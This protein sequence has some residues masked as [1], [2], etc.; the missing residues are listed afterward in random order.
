MHRQVRTTPRKQP[1]QERSKA[2][3]ET[4]LEATARVLVKR[5]YDGLTTN[6][7][8]IAAGV[9][10]GSLYQY[11]PNKEALVAGLIGRHGD[12]MVAAVEKE[13]ARVATLPIPQAVRAM[14]ELTIRAHAIEPELH[15][16]LLEQV[17]RTG[18][19]A[20]V[21]ELQMITQRQVANLL[22][23]RR[24]ELAIG[25]PEIAAFLLVS[26][27]EAVAHRAALF[28]PH[29]LRD[30]KLIDEATAMVTRYLGVADT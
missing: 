12:E 19:M 11:F 10:I 30:P 6:A 24:D 14:I 3:V 22:V 9:S 23:A 28:A 13:L 1:S 17:P 26:A 25:D 4:I 8:A 16:V 2:T 29:R 20:R 18:R 27:I 21:M 15:R 5:G 7:V